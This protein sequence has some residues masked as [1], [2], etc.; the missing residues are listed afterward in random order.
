M[1][2]KTDS[3][4]TGHEAKNNDALPQ[5]TVKINPQAVCKD[6]ELRQPPNVTLT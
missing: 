3:Q 5:V 2:C 6:E 4:Y 1:V